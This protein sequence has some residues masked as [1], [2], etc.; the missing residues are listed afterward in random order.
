M[1]ADS[2]RMFVHCALVAAIAIV[3]AGSCK[4]EDEDSATR[5]EVALG[6]LLVWNYANPR[7]TYSCDFSVSSGLCY[8]LNTNAAAFDCTVQ[9]G[10]VSSSMCACNTTLSVGSCRRTPSTTVYYTGTFTSASA[11]THCANAG[12]TFQSACP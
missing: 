8:N 5:E 12:G 6:L 9:G 2:S 3:L 4:K 1:K 10:T 11:Q 7:F